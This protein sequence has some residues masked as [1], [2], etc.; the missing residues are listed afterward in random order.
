VIDNTEKVLY[1]DLELSCWYGSPPINQTNEIIQI[2][3]VEADLKKI[4]I[5]QQDRYYVLCQSEIS[6]YCTEL[7]GIT[8]SDIINQG[9]TLQKVISLILKKYSPKRK[10]IFAWGNDAQFLQK[11]CM[12]YAIPNIFENVIDFGMY[13]KQ[14][15]GTNKNYSLPDALS[16]YNLAFEG[17]RHD[18][19][20]DAYN[21]A[22]LHLEMIKKLRTPQGE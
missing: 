5:I 2:G 12:E 19:L 7:T 3:I 13:F 1:L 9:Q 20:I 17:K 22:R 4:K 10:A 15:I 14:S 21:L 18:G 8:K 11:Q 6:D 16:Q